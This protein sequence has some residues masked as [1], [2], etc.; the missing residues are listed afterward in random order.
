MVISNISNLDAFELFVQ[1]E[2]FSE[3]LERFEELTLDCRKVD[4]VDLLLELKK[5][6]KNW[7]GVNLINR[8]IKNQRMQYIFPRGERL[9]RSKR[10]PELP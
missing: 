10:A 8:L 3:A 2:T 4:S 6:V 7:K 9:T 5:N 1:S